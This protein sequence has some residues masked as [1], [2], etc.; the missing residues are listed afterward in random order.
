MNLPG[1]PWARVAYLSINRAINKA[2][3]RGSGEAARTLLIIDLDSIALT[4]AAIDRLRRRVAYTWGIAPG[5][6]H[7]ICATIHADR[8]RRGLE[9]TDI[10]LLY[11]LEDIIIGLCGQA[12]LSEVATTLWLGRRPRGTW[13]LD[14]QSAAVATLL[15]ARHADRCLWGLLHPGI[16][17]PLLT[18]GAELPDADRA[19]GLAGVDDLSV[20]GAELLATTQPLSPADGAADDTTDDATDARTNG[21]A[22]QQGA[23]DTSISALID[24]LSE[25]AAGKDCRSRD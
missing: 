6:I 3:D 7:I 12:R 14:K 17:L 21:G 25:H 10:S 13:T 20:I 8:S 16:S 11:S 24:M 23:L 22:H 15:I 9:T 2:I 1:K 5:D 4:A 18:V 19:R